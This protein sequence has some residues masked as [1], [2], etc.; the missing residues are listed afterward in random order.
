MICYY[1]FM[2]FQNKTIV[3]SGGAS[4]IGDALAEAL[5]KAGGR[6]FS[7]DKKQPESPVEGVTYLKADLAKPA[8]VEAAFADIPAPIDIL[9]SGAGVMRR[10]TLFDTTEEEYDFLMNNNVKSAWVFIRAAKPKL[11]KN[12]CVVQ[13][14]SRHALDLVNNPGIYALSKSAVATLAE[15]L[16]LTCPEYDVKIMYPGPVLTQLHLAGKTPEEQEQAKAR[17]LKPEDMAA[18]I[19]DLIESE[20]HELRFNNDTWSYE[21]A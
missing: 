7:V 5:V 9:L 1:Y 3:V 17:A 12:A 19:I 20:H 15:I 13:I 18:K 11:A 2:S 8:E 14:A 10:G 6:V 21:V 16:K 4:G